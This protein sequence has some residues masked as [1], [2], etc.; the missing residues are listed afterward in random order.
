M[1]RNSLRSPGCHKYKTPVCGAIPVLYGKAM[2]SLPMRSHSTADAQLAAPDR[3]ESE[4][5]CVGISTFAYTHASHSQQHTCCLGI[6]LH[7]RKVTGS[8]TQCSIY[9]AE[10]ATS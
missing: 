7:N 8:Q 6:I 9:N 2:L 5:T 3:A 4:V 10:R 1:S